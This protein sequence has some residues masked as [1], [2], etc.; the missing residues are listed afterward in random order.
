MIIINNNEFDDN[1]SLILDLYKEIDD[2]RQNKDSLEY[3]FKIEKTN[4]IIKKFE[5][6]IDIVGRDKFEF[7]D[8]GSFFYIW[9]GLMINAMNLQF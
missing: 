2:L 8:D 7:N 1:M 3:Q 6:L 9:K 5:E 4:E